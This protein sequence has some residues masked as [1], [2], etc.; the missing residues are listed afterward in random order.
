MNI[1]RRCCRCGIEAK[2]EE[3]LELFVKKSNSPHGRGT[4]CKQCH[5]RQYYYKNGKKP[6]SNL[7]YLR[8]CRVCGL[9]AKS[10]NDLELFNKDKICLHGRENL[11]KECCNKQNRVGGKYH[12]RVAQYAKL[13]QKEVASKRFRF[14][15]Q[16]IYT[17]FPI[18][19]N[20]CSQCGKSYPKDLK[21]QTHLHHL[22]Y[23]VKHPLSNTVELCDS[24][25]QKLHREIERNEKI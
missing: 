15:K 3:D 12:D 25:H 1:L 21:I 22:I 18:R 16:R 20:T 23:D 2:N 8:K 24:C 4:I 5:L 6:R 7:S 11:C 14:L 10:I 13:K 19:V 9:E 17:D